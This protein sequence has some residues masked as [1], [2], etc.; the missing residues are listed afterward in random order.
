MIFKFRAAPCLG[1]RHSGQKFGR[2]AVFARDGLDGSCMMA[3]PLV[4]VGVKVRLGPILRKG[5]GGFFEAAHASLEQRPFRR[6]RILRFETGVIAGRDLI[7]VERPHEVV[8]Y[9]L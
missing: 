6:A 4:L 9:G 7:P 3:N 8:R 2:D 5:P 1:P